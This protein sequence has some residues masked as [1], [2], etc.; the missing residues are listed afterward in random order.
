MHEPPTGRAILGWIVAMIAIL[1]LLLVVHF[2]R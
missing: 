2:S 1:L